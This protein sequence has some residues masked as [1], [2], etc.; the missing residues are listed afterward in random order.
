MP[1][2]WAITD[3]GLQSTLHALAL[4]NRL[5]NVTV[6]KV[7]SQPSI[8]LLP[9]IVQKSLADWGARKKITSLPWY[10]Q[11][12]E[13]DGPG[14]EYVVSCGSDAVVPG[15]L[16]VLKALPSRPYSV[17]LGHPNL[18]FLYFDQV[19]LS[20]HEA[21]SKMAKLG[22]LAQQ[23][24]SLVTKLPILDIPSN[25]SLG[26]TAQQFSQQVLKPLRGKPI[27]AVVVGG[28]HPDCRW[29]TEHAVQLAD[30]VKRMVTKLDDNV[31]VIFTDR[32]S[33]KNKTAILDT[34]S[35]VCEDHPSSIVTWDMTQGDLSS[36]ESAQAYEHV[37]TNV[38]RVALTADLDY[39][40]AH[41]CL[42]R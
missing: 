40:T 1:Q 34:L 11:G 17:F 5:G 27:T 26:S 18:P 3:G 24:N 37:L 31:L 10:L 12:D 33:E 21:N 30:Q 29:Y 13:L 14:P 15:S 23:R 36:L 6:K 25:T 20:K 38:T 35:P 9:L 22:P 39:L 41:A 2:V 32:A 7:V 16:H 19:V 4:A 8:R 28:H 42:F